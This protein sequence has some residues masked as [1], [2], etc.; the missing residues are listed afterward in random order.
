MSQTTLLTIEDDPIVRRA[1]VSYLTKKGFEVFQAV[2]GQEGIDLF[3]EKRPDI[4]LT[5][6]ALP[7]VDGLTFLSFVKV[8]S[9][10]TPVIIVS[11]MGTLD[12]AIKALHLGAWDY[13]T[14]PITDMALL[15]HA[16]SRAME[17]VVLEEQNKRYQNYLEEEVK[18]RT[19]ELQQS[20]K[21]EAVG[22]LA[23]G[24]AHDFNNI[25]SA[26]MG[27]TDLSLLDKTYDADHE[28][29]LQQ[30]KKACFRA[31]D[32]VQQI[33]TFSRRSD[34]IRTPIQV[35]PTV[36]EALKLLRASIPSTVEII[37][38]IATGSQAIKVNPTEI[39]QIIMN[40]CTNSFHSMENETGM[41]EVSL[42]PVTV[43]KDL[44]DAMTDLKAGHYLKITV[45]D[46]GCGMEPDIAE[47]VFDPFFTTKEPGKG[48]GMGLSV[49]HGIVCDCGG[50]IDVVSRPGQGTTFDLYFPIVEGASQESANRGVV[51]LPEGTETVLFVDDEPELV[52]LGEKLLSYLGYNVV[53]FASA[54]DALETFRSKPEAFDLVITD[55]TMPELPGSELGKEIMKIRRDIPII[56][57][58]GH[59]SIITPEKAKQ[60]GFRGFLMKPLS[61]H[62]LA[63]K[64]RKALGS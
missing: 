57:C 12:D 28:K 62:N 5:D 25:L 51:N 7:K 55:Q 39:H 40:L 45:R 6:L 31:R 56:L 42:T 33:L 20:Q 47:Q 37:Q 27:Y 10:D 11:G 35:Y 30:I 16:V 8:N 59:S 15:G 64:A 26:I 50:A 17:R 58:T 63:N 60:L 61:I 14:K 23:G 49:V 29:K 4:V 22:T 32:L 43:D 3:K 9:P 53:S 34:S 41:L 54:F 19:A 52:E 46:S 13:I 1:I 18:K 38:D 44:A 48:T 21:L 24:I 36:K 2:D